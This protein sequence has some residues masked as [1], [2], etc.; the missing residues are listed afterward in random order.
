M[1]PN[2]EVRDV[3]PTCRSALPSSDGKS[4]AYPRRETDAAGTGQVA[5]IF[6]E[7]TTDGRATGGI[8]GFTRSVEKP[9]NAELAG[10]LMLLWCLRLAPVHRWLRPLE[11]M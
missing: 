11:V 10:S 7:G 2:M 8:C 9:A 3:Y 5:C 4:A 6:P 1:H